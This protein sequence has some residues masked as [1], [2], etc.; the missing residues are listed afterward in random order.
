M[1]W[2]HCWYYLKWYFD[3]N[4]WLCEFVLLKVIYWGNMPLVSCLL[5]LSHCVASMYFY[6][7][8]SPSSLFNNNSYF[9]F[10]CMKIKILLRNIKILLLWIIINTVWKLHQ[11]QWNLGNQFHVSI[12]FSSDKL[13][14]KQSTL[15]T[16]S[17]IKCMV[18]N[19]TMQYF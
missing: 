16:T 11:Q 8:L 14:R 15:K 13:H 18:M 4:D 17:T 5:F 10:S 19:F 6:Q 12:F 3:T 2:N 1:D 9:V 7:P